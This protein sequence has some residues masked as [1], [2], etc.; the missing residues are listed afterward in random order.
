MKIVIAT[1]KFRGS[2]TAAQVTEHLAV[3]LLKTRDDI[4]VDLIPVAD[5]G[6]GTHEAAVR[7]GFRHHSVR[8]AGPHREPVT[9]AIA[10]QNRVAVV[11]MA[12]ASGLELVEGERRATEATSYGTG[13]LIREALDLGCNV[14]TLG[15]GGSASTDGGVGLL[16][17]LGAEFHGSD[18]KPVP[19]GGGGLVDIE[20]V[21]LSG[22]DPRL[23]NTRIVLATDVDNP[24][25]GSRGAAPIFGP[26]K[27][28]SPEEIEELEKGLEHLVKMLDPV[29]GP[30]AR[31]SAVIP[32]SGAAGGV[33]FAAIAVLG[34]TR[35]P[36]IELV[37]QLTGLPEAIADADLV[38][39]GE[40]SF[41]QQ[42]LGGKTPIGVADAAAKAKVPVIA[43]CGISDLSQEQLDAAGFLACYPLSDIAENKH[44]S[45]TNAAHLLERIGAQIAEDLP[46]LL[47]KPRTTDLR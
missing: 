37:L 28:A 19:F 5:G 31:R 27:G 1:D 32:G 17:A 41:D 4:D 38:I 40:G 45:I 39:T 29:I 44:D 34:A 7:V 21:N 13:Q 35:E 20:K 33:G 6:E 47:T 43:V 24:M 9:A 12:R 14:I 22:L 10:V 2:L 8:V 16:T 23:E 42:S 18:R 46:R 3:G 15:I 25:L 26:Q 11:E 30:A 36:G